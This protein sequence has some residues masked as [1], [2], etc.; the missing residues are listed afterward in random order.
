MYDTS[1]CF[2][3]DIIVTNIDNICNP[4]IQNR[5]LYRAAK[6]LEYNIVFDEFHEFVNCG[7]MYTLFILFMR[8][9]SRYTNSKT[10]LMSAS[11]TNTNFMWEF[12]TLDKSVTTNILPNKF[13]HFDTLH[14][15]LINVTFVDKLSDC[16]SYE[17]KTMIKFNSVKNSQEYHSK[18]DTNVLFHHKYID[19]DKEIIVKYLMETFG[20]SSESN[21][22]KITTT[23]IGITA[24]DIS[25]KNVLDSISSPEDSI[26][27]LGRLNRWGEFDTSCLEIAQLDSKKN[28]SDYKSIQCRYDPILTEKWYNFLKNELI[29]NNV[30]LDDLL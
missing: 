25:F 23:P 3:S 29:N 20:K 19:K 10:L 26:Q 12:N 15:K 5:N 2:K 21:N 8:A 13:N 6:I 18:N 11:P 1:E 22:S 9:R 24:L 30:I 17:N 4:L 7:A 14:K 28:S 16:N 27:I